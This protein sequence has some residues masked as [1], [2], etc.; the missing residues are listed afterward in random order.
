[1]AFATA[2]GSG[3]TE[4]TLTVI[5]DGPERGRLEHKARRLGIEAQV[6][7]LGRLGRNAVQ[8]ALWHSHAFV[9]PSLHETFGVVLL[10][11]MATGLPV[12]ATASGGPEDLVTPETGMLVPPGDVDALADAL[13]SLRE[14]RTTYDTDAIR[15]YVRDQFG[16]EAFVRRTRALYRRALHDP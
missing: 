1:M 15:A 11:A 13:A 6:Q 10:E 5:G 12:V 14:D 8:D 16:P 2:F 7:F 9:L 4:T 3:P